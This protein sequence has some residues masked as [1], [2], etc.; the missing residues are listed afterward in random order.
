[1]EEDMPPPK[2]V[3]KLRDRAEAAANASSYV[4]PETLPEDFRRVVHDLQVHQI[5][6]EM[7]NEELRSTQIQLLEAQE[8]LT[9]LY[10]FAPVGY[11]SLSDKGIILEANLTCARMLGLERGLILRKP[12]STFVL[13]E[14]QDIFYRHKR[15]VLE[16]RTLQSSELRM[17]TQQ[18]TPFWALLESRVVEGTDA[19]RPTILITFRNISV[20]KAAEIGLLESNEALEKQTAKAEVA[21]RAK[22]EFLA[23]MSHEIRT[24]MN[25]VIGMTELLL[26]TGLDEEQCEFADIIMRS[27][28][29]LLGVINDILDFSKIEA[30]KLEIEKRDFDLRTTLEDIAGVLAFSVREKGLEFDCFIHPDIPCLLQGDPIRL[31]QILTNLA[32]NAIKFTEKGE[33]A[34]VAERVSEDEQRVGLRFS[35]RDTGIGIAKE[36]QRVIF[37][38]FTQ[39]DGSTTRKYGGTGLGLT[40]SKQLIEM[41]GGKVGLE[42]IEGEGSTFWFLCDFEKQLK[43]GLVTGSPARDV[44]AAFECERSN[45]RILVV[46]DDSANKEVVLLILKK[47]GYSADIALNGIE[48]IDA[49]ESTPYDLV[50][51]D[52]QMPEMSGYDATQAIR[53]VHSKV[54]NRHVPVIA[55]TAEVMDGTREK[56]IEAG[57]DDYLAK[58]VLP[59]VLGEM[60]GKW[61]EPGTED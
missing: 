22:S 51:M 26:T 39:A 47:L 12:I 28:N 53:D 54:L 60:L 42:S 3:Q 29:L 37:D 5:E 30:G 35:V 56:C 16:E 52:C 19:D 13:D 24:P 8:H 33:V 11:M 4:V 9:E 36:R 6:L 17:R 46:E 32:A 43:D 59:H 23:N 34:I 45:A 55:M 57:M 38:G 10:D 40:I 31:N 7:Q 21:N 14:D 1:M 18:G 15:M 44:W 48:S 61:L 2:N 41:M 49:L 20:R 27:G 25:G 50:L 58:P